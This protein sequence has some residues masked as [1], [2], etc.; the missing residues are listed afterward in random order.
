MKILPLLFLFYSCCFSILA[1]IPISI[2]YEN[3]YSAATL[4]KSNEKISFSLPHPFV[5]FKDSVLDRKSTYQTIVK[6][7]KVRDSLLSECVK[8][9][10]GSLNF[11]Q[12]FCNYSK[13]AEIWFGVSKGTIPT[14]AGIYYKDILDSTSLYIFTGFSLTAFDKKSK[15]DI[16]RL[17]SERIT[18]ILEKHQKRK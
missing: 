2:P 6:I 18:G 15:T 14:L 5:E 17:I 16:S 10:M 9:A 1:Q 13:G 8:F 4:P 12:K 7:P 11:E 3:Y